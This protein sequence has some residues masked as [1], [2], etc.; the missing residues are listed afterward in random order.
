MTNSYAT[1]QYI[2]R[3]P[4][5]DDLPA[6]VELL[7][8]CAIEQIG[9]A[10]FSVATIHDEWTQPTVNIATD[11]RTYWTADG[12]LV[13]YGEYGDATETHIKTYVWLRIHPDYRDQDFG[14]QIL[15][16]ANERAQA[17]IAL[18][19]EG[20]QV[21]LEAGVYSTDLQGA[22]LL[23]EHGFQ[24]TRHFWR[25][26]R[27]LDTPPSAPVLPAGM[28]IRPYDPATELE[29]LIRAFMESFQDHWG[30]VEQPFEGHLKRW[31][32]MR[33]LHDYDPS[34]WFV[35]TDGTEVAGFAVCWPKMDEDPAMGWVGTLGVRR[36]WRRQRLGL[37]LLDHAF[38]EFYQRG[39]QRVGLGVDA[40]SLTGATKLYERAGMRKTRQY[41]SYQK[42]LRPGINLTTDHVD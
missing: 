4:T 24:L 18:A 34:L 17:S 15:A 42:I 20:A 30:F 32:H 8:I 38:S 19:P 39:Q 12:Q 23:Q 31:E 25:M 10:E 3:P 22:A 13:A 2:V 14:P 27:E 28:T 37:A 16:W 1:E 29:P 11:R 9:A 41:D 5:F 40:A 36:Q 33:A 35:A 7:N 26:E 6:V 21:T